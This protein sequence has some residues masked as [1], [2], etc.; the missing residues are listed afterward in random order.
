MAN[1]RDSGEL[2]RQLAT[3]FGMADTYN[4]R[5]EG[6]R[7]DPATGTLYCDGIA[8]PK[9]SIESAEEFFAKQRDNYRSMAGKDSDAMEQFI[10]FSVAYN[11]I[12]MM[13]A[14]KSDND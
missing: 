10:N 2:I 13:M 12:V 7:F 9:S 11:A 8:V 4:S 3:S 5:I 6:S 1:E 14:Q